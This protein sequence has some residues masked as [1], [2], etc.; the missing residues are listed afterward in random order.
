VRIDLVEFLR[1]AQSTHRDDLRAAASLYGGD[2]LADVAI[3]DGAFEAW[4]SMEQKQLQR[5]LT[6]VLDRLVPLESGLA[7]VTAAHR[8]VELDP[9]REASQRLLIA[10]YASQGETALALK[11]FDACRALLKS[12]LGVEPSPETAEL[13]NRISS[14]AAARTVARARAMEPPRAERSEKPFVAV[15]P[16]SNLSGDP[17]QDYFSDG[18]TEDVITELSRFKNMGVIARNS[19]FA[20]RGRSIGID[21]IGKELGASYI[22][23]GSVRQ[24]GSRVRIT[25]QLSE[26]RSGSQVWAERFDRDVTD[27]FALQDEL[28]RNIAGTLAIE[29][30]GRELDRASGLRLDDGRAYEFFLRGKRQLWDQGDGMM[31]ARR[32][33]EKAIAIDPSLARAH[34]ALAVTYVHEALQ[35]PPRGEFQSALA[36]AHDSAQS[37]LSLDPSECFGHMSLAWV[38][39]YRLDY[40]RMKWHID[41]AIKL[42]PNDADMLAN[43]TYMLACNGNAEEAIRAG[44][45]AIRLNPRHPDWYPSFL[46]MALFTARRYQE[47]W[48]LRVRVPDTFYDSTFLG[49]ATLAYL[50]RSAEARSWADRAVKRLK[51]RLGERL[52]AEK[53][54]IQLMIENNPYRLSSDAEHFAEGMRRAGVTR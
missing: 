28:A 35:F 30:D 2:L 37:A 7:A 40:E 10:A 11:Q 9:L 4:Q 36:A 41:H 45:A 48:D 3:R 32:H 8:L 53:G 17:A 6:G 29:L 52:L 21:I 50:G 49:A 13:R 43:A 12:E 27:I 26:V 31:E 42:N 19:S 33:L 47:A 46:S 54:S 15:L 1:L 14:G 22:L 20:Y 51:G 16:F 5:E 38:Y 23:D 24:A 44:E 18:I 25:A 39:L 34:A